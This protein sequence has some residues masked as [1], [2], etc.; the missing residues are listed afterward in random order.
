MWPSTI[1]LSYYDH[2]RQSI[3]ISQSDRLYNTTGFRTNLL[4]PCISSVN[5]SGSYPNPNLLLLFYFIKFTR[6]WFHIVAKF[7]LR[8]VLSP[9]LFYL[10]HHFISSTYINPICHLFI[11]TAFNLDFHAPRGLPLTTYDELQTDICK[12]FSKH[13]TWYF[14]GTYLFLLVFSHLWLL[15]WFLHCLWFKL[16]QV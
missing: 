15:V 8:Q 1:S 10:F 16:L 11:D 13:I 7:L 6:L 2:F 12:N 3:F 9:W 14:W 5:A 4:L